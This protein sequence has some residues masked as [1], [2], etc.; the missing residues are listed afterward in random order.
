[1]PPFLSSTV[2]N[3][4]KMEL[5]R[6]VLAFAMRS[7]GCSGNR[8]SNCSSKDE[9]F[10]RSAEYCLATLSNQAL[11]WSWRFGCKMGRKNFLLIECSGLPRLMSGLFFFSLHAALH[12]FSTRLAQMR[13]S[14]SWSESNELPKRKETPKP[15]RIV[16]FGVPYCAWL[17]PCRT[18]RAHQRHLVVQSNTRIA[19]PFCLWS[20]TSTF[21][22]SPLNL[23]IVQPVSARQREDFSE[24]ATAANSLPAFQPLTLQVFFRL[25]IERL[26]WL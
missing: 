7:I 4:R 14:T 24:L 5:L 21:F 8:V 1:M 20:R 6:L 17:M 11:M 25:K 13:F 15:R 9:K 16:C 3:D 2:S 12:L 19:H 22:S 10:I 23:R 18:L 26:H